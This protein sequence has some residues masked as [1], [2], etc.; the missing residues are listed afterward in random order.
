MAA[1]LAIWKSQVAKIKA[2]YFTLNLF[3][4]DPAR[5]VYR[6]VTEIISIICKNTFEITAFRH[7]NNY[8]GNS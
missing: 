1:E 3:D 2:I 5:K 4:Y 6:R 8:T 7:N